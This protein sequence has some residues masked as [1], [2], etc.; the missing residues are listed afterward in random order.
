MR[1]ELSSSLTG[2]A[3]LPLPPETPPPQDWATDSLRW[4]S[5]QQALADLSSFH[6]FLSDKEGLTGAEKWV[7]W[8]GKWRWRASF[9]V[10]G[11]NVLTSLVRL[12]LLS[13]FFGAIRAFRFFEAPLRRTSLVPAGDL[14]FN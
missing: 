9:A 7:T 5:S 10:L 6:G 4:L 3:P 12:C 1:K 13:F 8:G 2:H 14:D 11:A